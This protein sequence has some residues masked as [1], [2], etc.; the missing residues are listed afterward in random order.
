MVLKVQKLS[1]THEKD[2]ES[3]EV[4]R[5]VSFTVQDQETVGIVGNNGTGKTSLGLSL[6]KLLNPRGPFRIRGQVFLGDEDILAVPK[7]RLRNLRGNDISMIFQDPTVA[8]S[9][10]KS[11]GAQLLESVLWHHPHLS[12]TAAMERVKQALSWVRIPCHK[13]YMDAYP[14]HLSGGECQRMMIAMAIINEP[15]VLIADEP[16]AAL[17]GSVQ[18][19]ILEILKDLQKKLGMSILFISHDLPLVK[20]FCQRVLHLE[21]KTLKEKGVEKPIAFGKRSKALVPTKGTPLL[22]ARNLSVSFGLRRRSFFK[23]SQHH[24]V[25]GVNFSLSP[26]E[27]VG[28]MGPNG[29]GKSTFTHALM[30]LIPSKGTVQFRGEPLRRWS[31]H[32]LKSLHMIFQN[33]FSSLNPKWTVE[34]IVE[35]GLCIHNPKESATERLEKVCAALASVNLSTSYLKRYPE[36]LSGGEAQRVALARAFVLHPAFLILDEP[37]A[38]LDR[39][40]T[41]KL[42]KTLLELHKKYKTALLI[43]SH[44]PEVLEALC[45]RTLLM[46]DGHFV[47]G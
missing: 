19:E 11:M 27:I 15:K 1:I 28:L 24:A 25:R 5:E 38:S 12:E 14:F 44:E 33:P 2:G 40:S 3:Q 6:M 32:Y 26:G 7:E 20:Q 35:E 18:E 41:S 43:I 47:E 13:R 31:K 16:T 22:E 46:H 23:R 9:P 39:A 37:T 10:V 8:L 30:G 29:S 21:K 42:L 36:E 17:D 4:I 45:H 34:E